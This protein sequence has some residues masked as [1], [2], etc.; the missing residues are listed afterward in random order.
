MTFREIRE[1]QFYGS[2]SPTHVLPRPKGKSFHSDLSPNHR[3]HH[4]FTSR[5]SVLFLMSETSML[6]TSMGLAVTPEMPG[7]R[8]E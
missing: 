7:R 4:H 6:A 5:L 3:P 1:G 2:R 8:A